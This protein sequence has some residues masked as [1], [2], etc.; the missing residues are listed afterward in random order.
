MMQQMSLLD[1]RITKISSVEWCPGG[2]DCKILIL[3]NSVTNHTVFCSMFTNNK[4][5]ALQPFHVQK[6]STQLVVVLQMWVYHWFHLHT[7]RNDGTGGRRGENLPEDST[8]SVEGYT[9]YSPDT[10]EYR[11]L[12]PV[13]PA[14]AGSPEVTV[15]GDSTSNVDLSLSGNLA[16][17]YLVCFLYRE[18]QHILSYYSGCL[19]CRRWLD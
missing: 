4:W 9:P 18:K 7:D 10:N 11:T 5:K 17:C 8:T 12:I 6:T 2:T 3:F 15:V 1:I 13:T 14:K 16:I 19:L